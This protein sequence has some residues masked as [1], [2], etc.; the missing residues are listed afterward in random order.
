MSFPNYFCLSFKLSLAITHHSVKRKHFHMLLKRKSDWVCFCLSHSYL[1]LWECVAIVIL[2]QHFFNQC[3]EQLKTKL[4][5]QNAWLRRLAL[6]HTN[7]SFRINTQ[8]L[9]V[10]FNLCKCWHYSYH[11][12]VWRLNDLV[13]VV[14]F[15]PKIK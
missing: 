8:T 7:C 14:R 15:P 9:C 6:T 4:Q 1:H 5:N 3:A 12:V 13:L 2:K 10:S 11:L